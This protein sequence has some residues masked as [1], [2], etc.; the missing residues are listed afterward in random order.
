MFWCLETEKKGS[1]KFLQLELSDFEYHTDASN[2]NQ[3]P[4][5]HLHVVPQDQNETRD[6]NND[7][8]GLETVG[9][10]LDNMENL[11]QLD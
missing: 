8:D 1:N 11:K 2:N 7:L 5:V 4:L 10:N 6:N 9:S 3:I